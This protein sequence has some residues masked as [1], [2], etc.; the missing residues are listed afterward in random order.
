LVEPVRLKQFHVKSFDPLVVTYST[1]AFRTTQSFQN[2]GW[3]LPQAVC[4]ICNRTN[5][6]SKLENN[7]PEH[8]CFLSSDGSDLQD[9]RV[10]R[11]FIGRENNSI[12]LH[13]RRHARTSP[14]TAYTVTRVTVF[15]TYN[16]Y[17]Y[18]FPSL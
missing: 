15:S 9:T 8:Y 5:L 7:V 10:G 16:Y 18:Y 4:E 1:V 17:Y 14:T 3:G 13:T 11:E 6:I 12:F 2:V